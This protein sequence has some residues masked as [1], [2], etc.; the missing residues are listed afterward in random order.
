[1][2]MI[3]ALSL[4]QVLCLVSQEFYQVISIFMVNIL[5]CPVNNPNQAYIM[6]SKS[7]MATNITFY[8]FCIY[9]FM[10]GMERNRLK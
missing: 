8:F 1:M 4:L 2:S 9:A 6:V 7:V 10:R 3:P 5:N